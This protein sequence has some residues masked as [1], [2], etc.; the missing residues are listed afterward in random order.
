[1]LRISE[2]AGCVLIQ[3]GKRRRRCVYSRGLWGYNYTKQE[4]NTAED[5]ILIWL[6]IAQEGEEGSTQ[7]RRLSVSP[8]SLRFF[9]L[10]T[11]EHKHRLKCPAVPAATLM[12]SFILLGTNVNL[13]QPPSLPLLSSL[14]SCP[15]HLHQLISPTLLVST[16]LYLLPC[17]RAHSFLHPYLHTLSLLC[18]Y[19]PHSAAHCIQLIPPPLH[20]ASC[21]DIAH[22]STISALSCFVSL[23]F[24]PFLCLGIL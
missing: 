21:I 19:S 4:T 13:C 5:M 16:P 7:C 8:P 9:H 20:P 23:S 10:N 12:S 2:L 1:M 24:F 14:F 18:L 11:A 22:F 3:F 15:P 17:F 6:F